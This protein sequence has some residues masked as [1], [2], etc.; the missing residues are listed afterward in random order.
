MS[1]TIYT[2][3]HVPEV[4]KLKIIELVGGTEGLEDICH[5]VTYMFGADSE[6]PKTA[7]IEV[8]GYVRVD[9]LIAALVKV[10]GGTVRP[11]GGTYHITVAIDRSKYKP[12]D[13]NKV[14]A[15]NVFIECDPITFRA[16]GYGMKR[17]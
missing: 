9:G 2:G 3:Y 15:E 17:K 6:V 8:Y 7:T 4:T 12:V 10:D 16:N 11:D 5:H 1:R 14:I 13:S